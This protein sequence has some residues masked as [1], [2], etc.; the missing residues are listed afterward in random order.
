MN[1]WCS[2]CYDSSKLNKIAR[3]CIHHNPFTSWNTSFLYFL[4][5]KTKLKKWS[6]LLYMCFLSTMCFFPKMQIQN[7]P[8][9]TWN[10]QRGSQRSRFSHFL[11]GYLF[12]LKLSFGKSKGSVCMFLY[13]WKTKNFLKTII[14]EIS[15]NFEKLIGSCFYESELK[16]R[17]L[18]MW[19]VETTPK[20]TT[21]IYPMDIQRKSIAGYNWC[22]SDN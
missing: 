8:T 2:F 1:C 11:K 21:H 17:K 12:I 15:K 9:T 5:P 6:C 3:T 19:R 20:Q 22:L 10:N 13:F 16:S 7:T 18:T 14:E 4:K